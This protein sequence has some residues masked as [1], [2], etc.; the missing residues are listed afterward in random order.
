MNSHVSH[1]ACGQEAVASVIC[2]GCTSSHREPTF[3]TTSHS[4]DEFSQRG[5]VC[6][7]CLC[8]QEKLSLSE[9]VMV[10][11]PSHQS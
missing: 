11:T 1:S 6:L 3:K 2:T 4:D 10:E 9:K 7:L 5:I 8:K